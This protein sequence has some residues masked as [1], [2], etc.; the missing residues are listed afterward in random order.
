MSVVKRRTYVVG[1]G[2]SLTPEEIRPDE[3]MMVV[4]LGDPPFTLTLAPAGD[5]REVVI[6][7][8]D[9]SFLTDLH[10]LT[11]KRAKGR[12]LFSLIEGAVE[13]IE[14][15]LDTVDQMADEMME[16]LK[17]E[18]TGEGDDF[19][20]VEAFIEQ[21]NQGLISQLFLLDFKS[22][23]E[24]GRALETPITEEV[25]RHHHGVVEEIAEEARIRGIPVHRVAGDPEEYLAWLAR[26]E[27]MQNGP[28]A[29][30]AYAKY[31]ATKEQ[32]KEP[33]T[34]T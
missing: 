10:W 24:L 19:D 13:A 34:D 25:Y 27:G 3:E 14:Y 1:T 22:A 9:G 23:E 30:Q 18:G 5:K 6:G 31:K 28:E 26:Q 16:T 12:L 11:P 20:P 2:Y 7:L 4:H 15:E 29:A 21:V 8:S 17:G 33:G 32:E